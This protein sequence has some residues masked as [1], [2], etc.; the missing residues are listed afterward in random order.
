MVQ[1]NGDQAFSTGPNDLRLWKGTLKYNWFAEWIQALELAVIENGNVL[2][3][4]L[5]P[6]LGA[7]LPQHHRGHQFCTTGALQLQQIL[8]SF[9]WNI[10]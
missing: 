10:L 1:F 6:K 5:Q 7:V 4:Y 9:Q 2:Q 3:E 8:W